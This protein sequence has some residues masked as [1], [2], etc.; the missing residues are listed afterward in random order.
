MAQ[1]KKVIIW[2]C[3]YQP[4]WWFDSN[5]TVSQFLT[6][7]SPENQRIGDYTVRNQ[8]NQAVVWGRSPGDD[9]QAPSTAIFR[10]EDT[11]LSVI[12]WSASPWIR[13][14]D[15]WNLWVNRLPEFQSEW[16]RPS[17]KSGSIGSGWYW[18]TW[19][20][21]EWG[22]MIGHPWKKIRMKDMFHWP[23]ADT[24]WFFLLCRKQYHSIHMNKSNRISRSRGSIYDEKCLKAEVPMNIPKLISVRKLAKS[25]WIFKYRAWT[26]QSLSIEQ[27]SSPSRQWSCLAGFSKITTTS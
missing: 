10:D 2:N 25:S 21:K 26:G 12:W 24:S 13:K 4:A 27:F 5:E 3:L 1:G 8:G 19:N 7:R 15:F 18:S 14:V 16:N 22:E 11:F 6:R 17:E 20:R 9:Q 23:Y